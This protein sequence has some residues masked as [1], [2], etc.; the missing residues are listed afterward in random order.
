[1]YCSLLRWRLGESLFL[2]SYPGHLLL[3]TTGDKILNYILNHG[4]TQYITYVLKFLLKSRKPKCSDGSILLSTFL[5]FGI[6]FQIPNIGFKICQQKNQLKVLFLKTSVSRIQKFYSS[7]KVKRLSVV[8]MK[9]FVLK[10]QN[11]WTVFFFIFVI[12]YST[13]SI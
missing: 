7:P 13:D 1:M 4:E 11:F 2:H 9:Q 5:S 8:N 3:V 12:K 10:W 6:Q